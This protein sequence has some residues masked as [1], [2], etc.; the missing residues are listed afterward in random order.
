MIETDLLDLLKQLNINYLRYDHPPV[1]TVEEADL[2]L[3]D[4]SGLG[5]KNLFLKPEKGGLY[6]LLVV[7]EHKKVDLNRLGKQMGLGKLRFGTAEQLRERLGIEPGSVTLLAVV[8]DIEKKVR[9][10]V[11]EDLWKGEGLQCHPLTNTATLVIQPLD[12]THVLAHCGHDFELI[13]VPVR[14]GG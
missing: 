8:N 10:L 1:Y 11:D 4:A 12:L 2:H 9:V 7:L 13:E 5:T 14:P 3:K 6:L